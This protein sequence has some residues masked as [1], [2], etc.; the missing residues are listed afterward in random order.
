LSAL[1]KV[2]RAA[3]KLLSETAGPGNSVFRSVTLSFLSSF[4]ETLDALEAAMQL[5][6]QASKKIRKQRHQ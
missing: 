2:K 5:E 6:E 1:F 3:A 4:T